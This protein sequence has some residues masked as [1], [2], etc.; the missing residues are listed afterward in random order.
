VSSPRDLG[1]VDRL[2]G[3]YSAVVADVLD[4][5]GMRSQAMAPRIRPLYANARVAGFA[6]TVYC[7]E[8]SSPPP[9]RSDWYR[10]EL[11]AVDALKPGD[12]MVVST[13]PG[14]YWASCS[15]P[16]PVTEVPAASSPMH[17]HATHAR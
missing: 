9:D 5:L 10:G 7:V 13:C 14:C 2:E 1:V 8:V 15:P 11:E 4:H 17:T 3:L 12:V 6:A 16:P